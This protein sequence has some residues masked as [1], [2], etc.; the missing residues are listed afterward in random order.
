MVRDV[1]KLV[2][3]LVVMVVILV[4]VGVVHLSVDTVRIKR[5]AASA[6]AAGVQL[7]APYPADMEHLDEILAIDHNRG[8]PEGAQVVSVKPAVNF[9]EAMPS[10]WG[11]VIAFTAGDQAI[12]EYVADRIG[13]EYID[14]QQKVDPDADGAEDVDL[15]GVADPWMTGFG[16]SHLILERPLGRGWM[17]IR[18]GGR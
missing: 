11:Y 2:G 5:A 10:G 14:T 3:I 4:G 18:G 16:D 15:S 6:S 8:L 12:R 13:D 17:V 7:G 1:L 9:A